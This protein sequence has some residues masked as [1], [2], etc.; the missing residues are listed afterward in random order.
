M[1]R[2]SS[3]AHSGKTEG[4]SGSSSSICSITY[5]GLFIV[6]DG[7]CVV[8]VDDMVLVS[9]GG[10]RR[11]EERFQREGKR[12]KRVKKEGLEISNAPQIRFP[13]SLSLRIQLTD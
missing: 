6:V 9:R 2:Y 10:L 11:R 3:R 1:C 12:E 5:C 13:R 8:D 7:A 4:A